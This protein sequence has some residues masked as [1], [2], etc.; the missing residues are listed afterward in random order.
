MALE[1]DEP[2][3]V[4]GEHAR[5]RRAVRLM[6]GRTSFK[7]NWGVLENE[8]TSFVAMALETAWLV[9]ERSSHRLRAETGMRIMTIGARH[10]TFGQTMFVRFLERGPHREMA[11][12]TLLVDFGGFPGDKPTS[13]VTVDAMA[14]GAGNLI[15]GMPACD[16]ANFGFGVRVA[17]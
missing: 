13:V 8:R 3:F 15:F 1:T 11:G 16:A 10:G 5:I 9:A 2:Y 12:S 4:P 6:A 17:G 14:T 7:A